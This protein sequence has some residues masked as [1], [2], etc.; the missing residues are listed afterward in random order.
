M[1]CS[2]WV[3]SEWESD[4]NITIIHTTPVLQ[5][6]SCEE[7]SR[8]RSNIKTFLT[9]M[10]CFQ[11]KY[12]PLSIITLP[13][14]KS[15]L[16]WIGREI[17]KYVDNR[18]WTFYWR[19][20]YYGLWI[21][22]LAKAMVWRL[23]R[24]NH[25]FLSYKH[26][27]LNFWVNYSFKEH[28][29]NVQVL[30]V[31]LMQHDHFQPWINF[32]SN[33]CQYQK[34]LLKGIMTFWSYSFFWIKSHFFRVKCSDISMSFGS[35]DSVERLRFMIWKHYAEFSPRATSRSDVKQLHKCILY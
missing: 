25:G 5:L 6:M 7:K 28:C 3:P 12:D 34:N 14:V 31:T 9:K 33:S 20:H 1:L 23:R 15:V 27:N 18:R 11:L 4:K 16:V 35:L 32:T 10:F 8:N 2:E 21:H 22:L 13:P 30:F 17:C 29:H 19:K 24:F 26:A